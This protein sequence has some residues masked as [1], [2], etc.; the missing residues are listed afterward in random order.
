MFN[1]K[2]LLAAVFVA[3]CVAGG[4]VTSLLY[5]QP[6]VTMDEG[7]VRSGQS[8]HQLLGIPEGTKVTADDIKAGKGDKGSYLYDLMIL[9]GIAVD[10]L[11]KQ[12]RINAAYEQVAIWLVNAQAFFEYSKAIAAERDLSHG[13]KSAMLKNCGWAIANIPELSKLLAALQD[14]LV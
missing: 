13:T 14:R 8:F 9:Q 6:K 11:A 3:Q 5:Y 1:L 4:P 7:T 12:D 10:K 2:F